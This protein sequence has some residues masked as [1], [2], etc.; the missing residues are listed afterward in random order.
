[1]SSYEIYSLI[2]AAIVLILFI[3]TFSLIIGLLMKSTIRL[4]EY[5]K[6]DEMIGK[7]L[8]PLMNRLTESSA[9]CRAFSAFLT[10]IIVAVFAISMFLRVTEDSYGNSLTSLKVV[11]SDS[12]QEKNPDN[13]YLFEND[14]N[15]QIAMF[16]LIVARP[17]PGEF[18]L[19]LYDIV[20]YE[21]DGNYII[22]RIVGIEEPNSSH[23]DCRHFKLQGDA[24]G[25]YDRYPVLYE[26][27]IA[28]YEGEKV[29]FIGSFIMFL[30]SPAGWFCM[31]LILFTAIITPLLEK[32]LDNK[33]SRRIV[34]VVRAT[35]KGRP[36]N[37]IKKKTAK[38]LVLEKIERWKQKHAPINRQYYD[39]NK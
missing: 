5:G 11:Q 17:L 4:V 10:I 3:A 22:H 19:E 28:K 31:V 14:I 21:L 2:L 20:V 15:D 23:P 9:I 1:M 29:P 25:R 38:E 12:M 39:K 37:P 33:K 30:Q 7:E 16:D 24:I 26:Q 18:E 35:A 13:A 8:I 27:M 6:D 34:H 32:K 36:E